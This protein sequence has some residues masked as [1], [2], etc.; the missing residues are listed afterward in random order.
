MTFKTCL[1]AT[2]FLCVATAGHTQLLVPDVSN[3]KIMLFDSVTG[4]LMESSFIDTADQGGFPVNAVQIGVE[5]W[6]SN[7]T[8]E[9]IHRYSTG[10]LYL[11][12]VQGDMDYARGFTQVG[13]KVYAANVGT[14]T[15]HPERNG[16]A[17][18]DVATATV[19]SFFPTGSDDQGF[20]FDVL[21]YGP[22]ANPRLL[23]PDQ[24]SVDGGI[25]D[26]EDIDW[27]S[28]GGDF[29]RT[30]HDSDG[31]T[32]IDNPMQL[33]LTPRRTVLAAGFTGSLFGVFEYDRRGNEIAFYLIPD[34]NVF[35]VYEL[36][37]GK[38]L[39]TTFDGVFILDP[40]NPD[41]Q[42][43]VE[44]VVTGMWAGFIE[45]LRMELVPAGEG[46]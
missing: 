4:A 21:A 26:G 34:T 17:V 25:D 23:I 14:N 40:E 20:G 19:E 27:F 36:G 13:D 31:V 18:I 41:T 6:L 44:A 9:T 7:Q 10:G 46:W 24:S 22:R 37:N 11:G 15:G 1:A 5:I 16:V 45:P 2:V 28:T 29:L 39:F 12:D 32:G 8:N 43:N 42:S 38:I 30:F 35:G 33:S 3:G